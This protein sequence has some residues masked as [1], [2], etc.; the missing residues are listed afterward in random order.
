MKELKYLALVQYVINQT[1]LRQIKTKKEQLRQKTEASKFILKEGLL[2][3][4]KKKVD[5]NL[6]MQKHQVQV[7]IHMIYDHPLGVHKGVKTIVQ[8][9][10]KRYY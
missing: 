1:Y 5:F 2:K 10:R 9:I 8:K 7:I 6:V 3:Y 4:I